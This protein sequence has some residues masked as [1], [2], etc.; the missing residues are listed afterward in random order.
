[1]LVILVLLLVSNLYGLTL[2]EA[3]KK[4]KEQNLGLK[5]L[6][7][8]LKSF[9]GK[10]VSAKALE[11]P[12]FA[13]ESGFFSTTR[14]SGAEG[15]FIY[16]TEL[17]QPLP[18]WGVRGKR[19]KVVE[20][21]EKAFREVYASSEKEVLAKVYETFHEALYRMELLKI[22][23]EE[24][25]L[26]K[27]LEEFVK[28]SYQLGTATL[29]DYLRAKRERSLL[30]TELSL[31][32]KEYEGALR[33]LSL[34]LSEEVKSVEGSLEKVEG[35]KAFSP[36]ESPLVKVWNYRERALKKAIELEKALAKPS[37][38]MGLLVEDAGAYYGFR[39]T[40]S[41]DLPLLYRRKGEILEK[42]FLVK[43]VKAKREEALLKVKERLALLEEKERVLREEL[44]R[45]EEELIPQAK[46][47]LEVALKS[48][49][50]GTVSFFEL[51]DVR[52]RFFE[53][54]RKKAELLL[55]LHRLKA[56]YVS[57]GGEP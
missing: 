48:Y 9:E 45:F 31:A 46:E 54:L 57:L 49:R 40:L 29:L 7:E 47:E 30:L 21:E 33:E 14:G 2:E 41:S 16:L 32:R 8:E 4:A 19:L 50:L 23:Q 12:E 6:K 25:K 56:Q 35:I 5:A 51:T 36:E 15:R 17:S 52:R 22:T 18:L 27:E 13:F 34:L 39:L 26:S 11:N 43:S 28:K 24:L 20:E 3:L 44:R 53:L 42:S 1:M 55:L 37:V 38:R 10:K